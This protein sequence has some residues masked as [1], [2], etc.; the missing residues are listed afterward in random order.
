M[1]LMNVKDRPVRGLSW[2]VALTSINL[3]LAV[4]VLAPGQALAEASP[5]G[6]VDLEKAPPAAS[7]PNLLGLDE[8]GALDLLGPA[9][10]TESRGPATV[11]HYNT[12]QC[13]LDLFF[14]MEM[15]TGRMRTLHYDFKNVSAPAERQSCL[16]AIILANSTN[17][18]HDV[19]GE[20]SVIAQSAAHSS[21][22]VNAGPAPE[23]APAAEP[24]PQAWRPEPRHIEAHQPRVRLYS[25]RY[26]SRPV[27]T[28]RG[29]ALALRYSRWPAGDASST[30]WGGGLFGPAPYS[31]NGPQ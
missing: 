26:A 15:R 10:A 17:P 25:R 11:W 12:P 22:E 3:A 16:A 4:Y 27:W 28:G 18:S 29:Y 2:A 7:A 6:S 8:P 30:G 24:A 31:A 14:Y 21:A 1:D 13:E 23:I 20:N 9:K 5:A 19:P